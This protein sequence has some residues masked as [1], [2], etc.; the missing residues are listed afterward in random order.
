MKN[1]FIKLILP[2]II[3]LFIVWAF[4]ISIQTLTKNGTVSVPSKNNIS[5]I[6]Q[7]GY[8][9]LTED[10]A[11][12]YAM[13]FSKYAKKYEID[14]CIYPAVITIESSWDPSSISDSGAKGTMQVMDSTFKS[15][16]L[17]AKI[18][19]QDKKTWQNDV[20]LLG[21]GLDY[22]SRMVKTK[23]MERGVKGYIGGPK[24]SE[25]NL[26]CKEYWIKFKAEYAKIISLSQDYQRMENY[27]INKALNN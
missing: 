2:L 4:W 21:R 13:M 3:L 16:C 10:E 24:Y 25:T 26:Q 6:L 15:E 9:N 8:E 19:Y 11:D 7:L 23:G 27:I 1:I 18:S 22:L 5:G 20:I 14:W 17:K 12:F